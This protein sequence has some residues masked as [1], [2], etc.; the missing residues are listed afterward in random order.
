[1]EYL[2]LASFKERLWVISSD[3][4]FQDVQK[5]LACSKSKKSLDLETGFRYSAPIL[6][7]S[8]SY[9]TSAISNFQ[10]TAGIFVCGNTKE[11]VFI[12]IRSFWLYTLK[13]HFDQDVDKSPL[14]FLKDEFNA[15]FWT[16]I[17]SLFTRKNSIYP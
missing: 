16:P 6:I 17:F 4:R 3:E 7:I 15:A 2:I 13:P 1:M 11:G 8:S 9:G 5:V 10:G 14:V 12:N